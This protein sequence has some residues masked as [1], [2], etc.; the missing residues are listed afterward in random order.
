MDRCFASVDY[1]SVLDVKPSATDDDIRT[2]F[3]KLA[4]VQHP[5]KAAYDKEEAKRKFQS[6]VEAYEVL[7]DPDLRARFLRVRDGR[8]TKEGSTQSG[9]R[10][11]SG[12]SGSSSIAS[13][14]R[15]GLNASRQ[16]EREAQ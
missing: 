4:L 12:S 6:I 14:R 7:K 13:L 1:F 16:R 9:T 10:R 11:T 5:D 15:A 2:A 3:R 8:H